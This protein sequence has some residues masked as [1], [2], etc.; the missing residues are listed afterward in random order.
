M[1]ALP[2][3]VT[4]IDRLHASWLIQRGLMTGIKCLVRFH[5]LPTFLDGSFVPKPPKISTFQGDKSAF[6]TAH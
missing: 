6:S 1:R 2:A 3:Q 4:L 5:R